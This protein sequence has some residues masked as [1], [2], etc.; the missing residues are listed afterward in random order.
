MWPATVLTYAEY[1]ARIMLGIAV[2][3][4]LGYLLSSNRRGHPVADDPDRPGHTGG[5]RPGGIEG[6][7]GDVLSLNLSAKCS[8]RCW[9]L[10]MPEAIFCSSRLYPIR[11][12][13]A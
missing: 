6:P 1:P 11:W 3:I 4:G 8:S 5:D 12:K 9:T 2:L 13:S 10:P 7:G